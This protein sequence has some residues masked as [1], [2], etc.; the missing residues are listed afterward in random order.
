MSLVVVHIFQ[1]KTL[2]AFVLEYLFKVVH[3]SDSTGI[4]GQLFFPK[5]NTNLFYSFGRWK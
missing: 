2:T 3:M 4:Q 1:A 5:Q